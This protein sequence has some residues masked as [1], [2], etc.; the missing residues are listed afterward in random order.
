MSCFPLMIGSSCYKN[1]VS[2]DLLHCFETLQLKISRC[3]TFI[4]K[5]CILPA[6]SGHL[7]FCRSPLLLGQMLHWALLRCSQETSISSPK[8]SCLSGCAWPWVAVCRRASPSTRLL[9]V[10]PCRP[11]RS[12]SAFISIIPS[13]WGGGWWI[14]W[15]DLNNSRVQI[16]FE[17]H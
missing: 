10:R 13:A 8:S 3:P 17:F 16:Y 15:K 1:G 5:A 9:L 4:F 11:W 2:A 14:W 12:H 6:N 7:T